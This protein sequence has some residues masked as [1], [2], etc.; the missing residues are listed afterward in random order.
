LNARLTLKCLWGQ[1]LNH[2]K[3]TFQ[4]LPP[5]FSLA[6]FSRNLLM[7]KGENNEEESLTR[8]IIFQ[9]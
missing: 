9:S 3:L 6:E 5:P 1:V 2:K 4:D 7:E 8:F